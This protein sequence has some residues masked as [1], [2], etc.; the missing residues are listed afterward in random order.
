MKKVYFIILSVVFP[1]IF[2][3]TDSHGTYDEY[4]KGGEH[5]YRAIAKELKGFSGNNSAKLTW[6]LTHP[7]LVTTCIICDGDEVLAELPVQYKDTV[8]LEYTLTDLLEKVYTFSVYSLDEEGNKSIKSDVIVEVFGERYSNTLKTT[9]SIK[10]VL[11]KKENMDNVL[12]FLSEVTST[13][14]YA[15]DIFYKNTTG[16]EKS[17]RLLG[18]VTQIEIE[19]VAADS[20][21]KIQDIYMPVTTSID[22]FPATIKEYPADDIPMQGVRTFSSAYRLGEDKIIATLTSAMEGTEYSV[23]KYDA[24]EVIVQ[25]GTTNITLEEVSSDA[26][27]SIETVFVNKE[28]DAEFVT[29]V[30]LI[31]AGDLLKKADMQDWSVVDYSSHQESGEGASGGNA[32][33]AID[34]NLATFWHTEYSPT[35][36]GYPHFITVDMNK[37][38][39]VK[40]VAVARRNNNNNI[41]SKMRLEISEN[42]ENWVNAGEFSPN[43]NINGLQTFELETPTKGRYFRLTGLASATSSTY[44]CVSEINIYE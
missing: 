43:S 24:Q 15:T 11:R 19:D 37:D 41:A 35:Q 13:K 12:V 20:Y 32:I 3:C 18:D 44:M 27:I 17:V 30:V 29:P 14:M 23:I 21:F 39:V 34:D 31:N 5:V 16:T 2:S 25:P 28:S 1:I 9:R 7:H 22:V 26:V 38:V 40:A 4:L 6:I 36:P 10:S 8:E 42:G 33:H